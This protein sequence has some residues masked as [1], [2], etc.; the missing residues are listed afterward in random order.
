M[1]VGSARDIADSAAAA[2]L[3]IHAAGAEPSEHFRGVWSRL[4]ANRLAL[5][6]GCA[7]LCMILLALTAPLISLVTG[8]PPDETH[9]DTQLNEFGVP[10]GPS[11]SFLLGADTLGRDQ[12]VRIAYGARSAL[13]VGFLATAISLGLGLLLGMAAGFFRG[14]ADLLLSRIIDLFLVMPVLLLALGLSASCGGVNGC[15]GG[16]VKPGFGLIV[17]VIGLTNWAY[18][19]RVVRGQVISLRESEFVLAARAVGGKPRTILF[20]E[21]VPNVS[22]SVIVLG[23][24]LFPSAI[25]YEAA[26]DFLGIGV[27]NAPSWGQMLAQAGHLL[28]A[29]WWMLV[30][31][32]LFLSIT[33]LSLS[34]LGEGLRDALEPRDAAD[35]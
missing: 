4:Q 29:A 31:P 5:V 28:P 1:S 10:R 30:F 25:L 13:L 6:G 17:M 23:L 9:V 2:A 34:L 16:L 8:H 11:S 20:T 24:I 27:P 7:L 35:A 3:Q 14:A 32:A 22:S 21:I 26:L 15:A 19:A 18:V 33:I 12:L